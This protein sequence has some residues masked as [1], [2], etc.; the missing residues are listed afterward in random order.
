M[1]VNKNMRFIFGWFFTLV[2]SLTLLLKPAHFIF[3]HHDTSHIVPENSHKCL[4]SA[5]TNQD[6]VICDFEFYYFIPQVEIKISQV[7]ITFTNEL[8]LPTISRIVKQIST[9]FQLR[10]PPIV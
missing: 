10:A 8:I 7:G 5:R 9:H 3:I 1:N 4:Y 6:C 2:F